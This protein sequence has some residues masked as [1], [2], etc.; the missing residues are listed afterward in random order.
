M[1]SICGGLAARKWN[2][3]G[4]LARLFVGSEEALRSVVDLCA[5]SA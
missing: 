4:S 5:V 2:L 1:G 3:E